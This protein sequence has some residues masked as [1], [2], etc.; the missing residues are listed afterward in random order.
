[1]ITQNLSSTR[2]AS[3]DGKGI[4]E[5]LRPYC[6]SVCRVLGQAG[7]AW[8]TNPYRI[9]DI[10]SGALA[11]AG[12][13]FDSTPSGI[14]DLQRRAERLRLSA[15]EPEIAAHPFEQVPRESPYAGIIS[16]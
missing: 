1:M 6:S 5:T 13:C 4:P 3:C 9:V 7:L 14:A 8:R 11:S 16:L 10:A 2:C 15:P 12:P